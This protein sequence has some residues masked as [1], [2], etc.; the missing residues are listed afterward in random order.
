[1]SPSFN[2]VGALSLSRGRRMEV[3]ECFLIYLNGCIIMFLLTDLYV[4]FLILLLINS[5][6][7]VWK[8]RKGD[9]RSC[10]GC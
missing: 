3:E 1:M 9:L 8:S 6:I 2:G 7:N 10:S 4:V 5:L